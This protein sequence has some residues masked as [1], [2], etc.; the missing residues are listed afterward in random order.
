MASPS[1]VTDHA[2]HG[3]ITKSGL[4]VPSQPT[5][6]EAATENASVGGSRQHQRKVAIQPSTIEKAISWVSSDNR[7]RILPSEAEGIA[8]VA[9]AKPELPIGD[10]FHSGTNVHLLPARFD[11]LWMKWRPRSS[12]T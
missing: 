11:L 6:I 2:A 1:A 5:T 7:P 3:V 12:A 4:G 9:A 8:M 10:P